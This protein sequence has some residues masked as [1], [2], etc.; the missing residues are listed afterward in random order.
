MLTLRLDPSNSAEEAI[1][2]NVYFYVSSGHL[3]WTSDAAAIHHNMRRAEGD[4]YQN[5]T[6][7]NRTKQNVV[8]SHSTSD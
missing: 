8:K 3:I 2:S 1:E 6:E 4:S 5:R 7:Q